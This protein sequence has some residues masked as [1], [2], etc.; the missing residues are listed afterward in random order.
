MDGTDHIWVGY[1]N[2]D[3]LHE[4]MM[5]VSSTSNNIYK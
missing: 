3:D 5:A 1:N 2:D 4:E